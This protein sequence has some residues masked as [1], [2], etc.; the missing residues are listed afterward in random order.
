MNGASPTGL[1]ESAS[2]TGRIG[3]LLTLSSYFG[4][5]GL[6][7]LWFTWLEPPQRLPVA[8]TVLLWVGPLLLPLPGLLAGRM[9]AKVWLSLLALFYFTFGVFC[10]A[11]PM[12][13]PWLAWMA[14]GLSVSLFLGI[15]MDA[16]VIPLRRHRRNA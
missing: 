4:L 16:R 13:R 1:M 15:L 8:L 10:L 11:G 2:L 9:R 14:T 12:T 3:R 5:L 7:M 6:L